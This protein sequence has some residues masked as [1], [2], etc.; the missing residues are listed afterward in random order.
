[1]L[2]SQPHLRQTKHSKYPKPRNYPPCIHPSSCTLITL[3]QSQVIPWWVLAWHGPPNEGTGV[4]QNHINVPLTSI[5]IHH[6]NGHGGGSEAWV[7]D[8]GHNR[9]CV[10]VASQEGGRHHSPD[11][12]NRGFLNEV[13]VG[14]KGRE[15]LVVSQAGEN[16]IAVRQTE[17]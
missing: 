17:R 9:K 8:G 10:L 3:H 12:G 13:I 4:G 1:M 2:Q 15:G 11:V 14:A 5:H 16:R 7:R 6:H